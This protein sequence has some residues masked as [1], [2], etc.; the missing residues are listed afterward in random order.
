MFERKEDSEES[1]QEESV[2]MTTACRISGKC[3]YKAPLRT[4]PNKLCAPLFI[5]NKKDKIT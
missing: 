5:I 3:E 4:R 1:S 2:E